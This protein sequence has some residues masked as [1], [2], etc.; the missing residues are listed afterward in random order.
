MLSIIIQVAIQAFKLSAQPNLGI[1][2][3]LVTNFSISDDIQ[4]LSFQITK[5]EFESSFVS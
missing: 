5:K 2:I 3:F 4:L 1:V